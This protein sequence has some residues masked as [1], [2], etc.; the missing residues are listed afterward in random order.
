M[1]DR[2]NHSVSY[3]PLTRMDCEQFIRWWRIKFLSEGPY[4]NAPATGA[5]YTFFPVDWEPGMEAAEELAKFVANESSESSVEA[6]RKGG[7]W[8]KA[9]K[10][11]TSVK[12]AARR[13]VNRRRYSMHSM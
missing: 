11:K 1:L 4:L 9:P 5:P 8:F 7:W 6:V 12:R 2:V 13:K 10:K 3:L